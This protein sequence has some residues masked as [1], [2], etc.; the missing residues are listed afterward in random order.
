MVRILLAVLLV[1]LIFSSSAFAGYALIDLGIFSGDVA[2]SAVA[3]DDFG[4]VVGTRSLSSSDPT[5]TIP[6]VWTP[7]Y[8]MRTLKGGYGTACTVSN[9][10]VGGNLKSRNGM[11]PTIW[12]A[13]TGNIVYSLPSAGSQSSVT[14]LS[15]GGIIGWTSKKVGTLIKYYPCYWNLGGINIATT[16]LHTTV[17]DIELVA[18]TQESPTCIVLPT[19]G[20]LM[21]TDSGGECFNQSTLEAAN[22]IVGKSSDDSSNGFVYDRVN[23]FLVSFDADLIG[24]ND[25][26]Q[27]IGQ[28]TI[29]GQKTAFTTKGQKKLALPVGSVYPDTSFSLNT[30]SMQGSVTFPIPPLSGYSDIAVTGLNNICGTFPNGTYGAVNG[31]AQI[32]RGLNAESLHRPTPQIVGYCDDLIG[33]RSAIVWT[34]ESGTKKLPGLVKGAKTQANSINEWGEIVGFSTAVDGKSHAVLWIYNS[35]ISDDGVDVPPQLDPPLEVGYIALQDWVVTGVFSD[36]P[37]NLFFFIQSPRNLTGIKIIGAYGVEVG[38]HVTV[39]GMLTIQNGEKRITPDLIYINNPNIEAPLSV[40]TAL[41]GDEPVITYPR[42]IAVSNRSFL[43]A[44]RPIGPT[45]LCCLTRLWGKIIGIEQDGQNQFYRI[46]DGTG[47]V[48]DPGGTFEYPDTIYIPNPDGTFT[49]EIVWRTIVIPPKL[50]LR[51]YSNDIYALGSFQVMTGVAGLK[52]GYLPI[53]WSKTRQFRYY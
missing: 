40:A 39:K 30:F 11:T 18:G 37:S 35:A 44:T 48:E 26:C 53:L 41:A 28:R 38:D 4:Y 31:L 43:D 51:V 34:E 20:G 19:P 27:I 33:N 25:S 12:N 50:G 16:T 17:G 32:E 13:L 21:G 6:F 29:G 3:I 46:D 2:T 14:D 47:F 7:K 5:E 8:G 1:S 49:E 52:N 24:I 9:S 23:N 15:G 36:D 42:P 10:W 45:I 22:L